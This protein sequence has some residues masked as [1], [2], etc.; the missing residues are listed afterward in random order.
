MVADGSV[1]IAG[2]NG[3]TALFIFGSQYIVCAHLT[4]GHEV[5]DA[6]RAATVAGTLGPVQGIE[7]IT[8]K[9]QTVHEV[10]AQVRH[11]L[12]TWVNPRRVVYDDRKHQTEGYWFFKATVGDP[13]VRKLWK[14]GA[15]TTGS[16]SPSPSKTKRDRE[17]S[18]VS[19]RRLKSSPARRLFGR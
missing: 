10:S 15:F 1:A 14:D 2:P 17:R 5:R 13:V 4:A 7:I 8:A 9:V 12:E 19:N 18:P 6:I 16:E 3:C 11:T